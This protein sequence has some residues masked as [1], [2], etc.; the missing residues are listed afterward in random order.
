MTGGPRRDRIQ[1]RA[2]VEAWTDA[3]L[4]CLIAD[5]GYERGA[6]RV[7]RRNGISRPSFRPGAG[8]RIVSPT[9]RKG[10]RRATPWNGASVR[11]QTRAPRDR[12][13]RPIRAAVLGFSVFGGG[14]DLAAILPQHALGKQQAIYSECP[15]T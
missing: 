15:S 4:S 7:G 6:F 10:T 8:A 12:P 2:L 3:P 11:A 5:R 1:A 9:P 14:L 13:L